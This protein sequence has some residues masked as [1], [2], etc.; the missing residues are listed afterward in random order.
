MLRHRFEL[1]FRPGGHGVYLAI[2]VTHEIELAGGDG[3]RFGA[4]A[5]KA[6]SVNHDD[7]L[8]SR[9][10]NVRHRSNLLISWTVDRGVIELRFGQLRGRETNMFAMVHGDF[11]SKDT[12]LAKPSARSLVPAP[13]YFLEKK[14]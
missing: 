5:E 3:Y 2:L 12:S 8:S 7:S 9:A 1:I 13:D 10:V 14:H 6:A 4:D 11:S